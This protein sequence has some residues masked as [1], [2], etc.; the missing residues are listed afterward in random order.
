MNIAA[1]LV[2]LS[3]CNTGVGKIEKEKAL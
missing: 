1:E 3:A 2:V